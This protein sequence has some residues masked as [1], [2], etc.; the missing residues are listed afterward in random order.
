MNL[1]NS[2]PIFIE[3]S[4]IPVVLSFFSPINIGAI[5]IGPIVFARAEISETTK[6]HESI[7]WQQY[8]ETGIV[9]F[10]I[11]Y[12]TYWLIGFVK[13]RDGDSAYVQIPFE[14]EA[15]ENENDLNY[16]LTRKRWSWK[17]YKI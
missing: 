5:T 6:N 8:I 11:L 13:Y 17:N 10:W 9:G 4:K 7:H 14:Q 2:K 1:K 3:N 12:I 15:Y 16:A